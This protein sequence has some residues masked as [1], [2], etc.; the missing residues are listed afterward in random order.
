M[1]EPSVIFTGP[2]TEH[3]DALWD[4]LRRQGYSPLSARNVLRVAAH[5]GRWLAARRLSL[6]ELTADHLED[7]FKSR[8]RKG[9]T[10]FLTPRA[11]KSVA[12][13]L[14]SQG[15]L[16]SGP[17]EE[18]SQGSALLREYVEYLRRERSLCASSTSAYAG[19]AREFL[20]RYL[21]PD[22]LDFAA[23]QARDVTSF[24]LESTRRYCTGATN[25]RSTAL[26]AFLLYLYLQGR[27]VLD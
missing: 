11:L 12:P 24:V 26:R 16:S 13:Y 14:R 21:G 2:L 6:Q 27:M 17:A 20:E 15:T 5:L 7:F 22:C 19:V 18:P 1:P 4:V 3:R 25:Y 8:R 9:Y 23:L 10:Q